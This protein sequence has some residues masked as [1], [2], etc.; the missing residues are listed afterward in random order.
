MKKQQKSEARNNFR[1]GLRKVLSQL[2]RRREHQLFAAASSR[3]ATCDNPDEE[4]VV[5]TGATIASQA[6]ERELLLAMNPENADYLADVHHGRAIAL[7]ALAEEQPVHYAFV[8]LRNR[9]RCLLDLPRDA[10]LLAHAY[11]VEDYR[12]RGCQGRSVAA[13]ARAAAD[14]GYPLIYAETSVDNASSRRGLEKAG[15]NDLGRIVVIQVLR[16]FVW[17]PVRPEGTSAF[18]I[19]L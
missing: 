7:L 15:M 10:A 17:R 8:L 1:R 5:A 4:F 16:I 6:R 3:L 13:R 11:T 19:C 9:T 14:A 2:Y 18:T 12:G